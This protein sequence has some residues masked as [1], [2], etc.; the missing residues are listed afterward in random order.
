MR[1]E[2]KIGDE[3]IAKQWRHERARAL[4]REMRRI[5]TARSR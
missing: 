4:R 2:E 5:R 3:E 1:Q